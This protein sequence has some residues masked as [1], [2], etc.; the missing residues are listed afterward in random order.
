MNR[1]TPSS[2]LDAQ[3]TSAAARTSGS[4]LA[5]ATPV[6]AASM[7]GM[8][9]RLSPKPRLCPRGMPRWSQS[10]PS[11]EPLEAAAS[12]TSMFMG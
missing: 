1:P 5:T 3:T 10:H 12:M 8:S 6:P 4:A 2:S 9:F 7:R 11:A